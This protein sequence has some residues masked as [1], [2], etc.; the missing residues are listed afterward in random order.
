M[1]PACPGG[2]TGRS[3]PPRRLPLESA[4]RRTRSTYGLPGQASARGKR[5]QIVAHKVDQFSVSSVDQFWMSLD[6]PHCLLS[7]IAAQ[8]LAHGAG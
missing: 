4:A 5:R 1:T 8:D 3:P 7:P 2:S 6:K